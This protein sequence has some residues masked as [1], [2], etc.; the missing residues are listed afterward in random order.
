MN[1]W[2]LRETGPSSRLAAGG[3]QTALYFPLQQN[4]PRILGLPQVKKKLATVVTYMLH[5][6]LRARRPDEAVDVDVDE[7]GHEELAVEPVH[8]ATVPR[9]YVPKILNEMKHS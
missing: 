3:R 5:Q 2:R 4:S 7:G 8:D 1:N 6:F 9:N